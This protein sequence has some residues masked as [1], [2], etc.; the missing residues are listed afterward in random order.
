MCPEHKRALVEVELTISDLVPVDPRAQTWRW[1]P[2]VRTRLVVEAAE[3][4]SDSRYA[5]TLFW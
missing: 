4:A 1:R 5:I 3:T 2:L